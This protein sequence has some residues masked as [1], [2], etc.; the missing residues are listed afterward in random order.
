MRKNRR[1]LLFASMTFCVW[2][3]L[4]S[5]HGLIA[6]SN[7]D[8]IPPMDELTLINE[9]IKQA[10][11]KADF[12]DLAEALYQRA[13]S[14]KNKLYRSDY[15]L[16][17]LKQSAI[18]FRYKKDTI[19]Y[20]NARMSLAEIYIRNQE[21]SEEA[22]R[23]L[24]ESVD[25]FDAQTLQRE[26]SQA[27]SLLS[28]AYE[29]RQ[30]Y[31][32]ALECI[33]KALDINMSEKDSLLQIQ[34]GIIV[35]RIMGSLSFVEQAIKI[36]EENLVL[37]KRLADD[38]TQAIILHDMSDLYYKIGRRH[39]SLEYLDRSDSLITKNSLE[40]IQNQSLFARLYSEKGDFL[41]AFLH[42]LRFNNLQDSLFQA[43]NADQINRFRIEFQAAD[44]ENEIFR[45]EQDQKLD[46]V[47]LKQKNRL[48][49]ALGLG[50]L[51]SLVAI[52]YVIRYYSGRIKIN[53]LLANQREQLNT[54]RINGLKND[55]K[56]QGL[57]SMVEGQEV[58]RNRIA[59]ELHDS[60]GGTL[61]ALKLQFDA[62]QYEHGDLQEDKN[63]NYMN[64]QLDEACSDV[65]N[66]AR[67]LK[68]SALE[69][70]GIE[71]AVRDL[72][73]RF[74]DSPI[75]ISLHLGNIEGVLKKEAEIHVYR[76]L[77]ELLTN[78]FRHSQ[79]TEIDIQ[80]T[81]SDN[82]LILKVE[83]DGIGFEEDK[84]QK[85]IGLESINTRVA[86]L[87]GELD[88]DSQLNGGTSFIIQIPL[89]SQNKK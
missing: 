10:R 61:S 83:D 1:P 55:V 70:V 22:I 54:Q 20:N 89:G 32:K 85:G 51:A 5:F 2:S 31:E 19:G 24:E 39:I 38:Q 84:I 69:S 21:F 16:D 33:N 45:L 65:R 3:V 12:G 41:R 62:L 81:R 9:R 77:Q 27:L 44:K 46:E 6:Q 75:D 42:Q 47:K 76:I 59:T 74:K 88:I 53:E 37:A 82:E 13:E 43:R 60:L 36:G 17:D 71:G 57:E 28:Q 26:K 80:L 56:I 50:V 15:L 66:I 4:F 63:Y 25:Y 30:N 87:F 29:N 52:F 8:T 34:N 86:V 11:V 58:E 67:N 64:H 40:D 49:I 68:P 73:N 72:I 18:Y 78:A 35:S 14:Q 79:A 48:L 7:I 23:I